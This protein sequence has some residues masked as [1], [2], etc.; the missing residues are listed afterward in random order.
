M[1]TAAFS[2]QECYR[3]C[4]ELSFPM[5]VFAGNFVKINLRLMRCY[6]ITR[7][8]KLGLI[9]L[10][11]GTKLLFKAGLKKDPGFT[12]CKSNL[13]LKLGFDHLETRLIQKLGVDVRKPV[14]S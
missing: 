5:G 14:L 6:W 13:N 12:A 2:G 11:I 3:V 4:R 7:P 10:V 9:W 1:S 8:L